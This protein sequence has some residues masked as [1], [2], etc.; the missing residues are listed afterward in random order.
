MSV[1]WLGWIRLGSFGSGR[2]TVYFG[3]FLLDPTGGLCVVRL[4][5]V[6][7][8]GRLEVVPWLDSNV[9]TRL[10]VLDCEYMHM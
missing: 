6:R 8:V 7:C 3:E 10:S 9:V 5:E 1:L 4:V 2:K